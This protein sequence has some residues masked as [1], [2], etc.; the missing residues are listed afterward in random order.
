MNN[1]FNRQDMPLPF[2]VRSAGVSSRLLRARCTLTQPLFEL[3]DCVRDTAVPFEERVKQ[4]DVFRA[5]LGRIQEKLDKQSIELGRANERLKVYRT[6]RAARN[7]AKI[8]WGYMKHVADEHKSAALRQRIRTLQRTV[9]RL[10]DGRGMVRRPSRSLSTKG[11]SRKLSSFSGAKIQSVRSRES[12]VSGTS[13]DSGGTSRKAA[14]Q[15]KVLDINVDHVREHAAYERA[16]LVREQEAPVMDTSPPSVSSGVPSMGDVIA[17]NERLLAQT[18]ESRKTANAI[19]QILKMNRQMSDGGRWEEAAGGDE[20]DAVLDGEQATYMVPG[21]READRDTSLSGRSD[22]E[23]NLEAASKAFYAGLGAAVQMM[24]RVSTS[25]GGP[26]NDAETPA[27]ME[28]STA[29]GPDSVS[30]DSGDDSIGDEKSSMSEEDYVSSAPTLKI[31]AF[32]NLLRRTESNYTSVSGSTQSRR[33]IA[34]MREGLNRGTGL[35][36]LDSSLRQGDDD[37]GSDSDS[38]D[39]IG[40]ATEPYRGKREKTKKKKVKSEALVHASSSSELTR[41][42]SLTRRLPFADLSMSDGSRLAAYQA[43]IRDLSTEAAAAKDLDGEDGVVYDDDGVLDGNE[44]DAIQDLRSRREYHRRSRSSA[45]QST[46]SMTETRSRSQL[47]DRGRVSPDR[48]SYLSDSAVDSRSLGR[49]SVR[50]RRGMGGT[51][52]SPS[53]IADGRRSVEVRSLSPQSEGARRAMM[54]LTVSR[55]YSVYNEDYHKDAVSDM[56]RRVSH[57]RK[58]LRKE[59]EMQKE[60]SRAEV[61]LG[62]MGKSTASLLGGIQGLFGTA[63]KGDGHTPRSIHSGTVPIPG[64]LVSQVSEKDVSI[65]VDTAIS[66]AKVAAENVLRQQQKHDHGHMK[67]MEWVYSDRIERLENQIRALGGEVEL[68]ET[69]STSASYRRIHELQRVDANPAE[70]SEGTTHMSFTMGTNPVS[71]RRIDASGDLVPTAAQEDA[72]SMLPGASRLSG[73]SPSPAGERSRSASRLGVWKPPEEAQGVT[74]REVDLSVADAVGA[75]LGRFMAVPQAANTSVRSLFHS[76]EI[77]D[78]TSVPKTLSV[79]TGTQYHRD[80]LDSDVKLALVT[81]E[82]ARGNTVGAVIS[83]VMSERSDALSPMLTPSPEFNAPRSRQTGS[84]FSGSTALAKGRNGDA[85][86]L[87]EDASGSSGDDRKRKRM[88]TKH[89]TRP[90]SRGEDQQMFSRR[91]VMDMVLVHAA[92]LKEVRDAC[93]AR[94]LEVE[95]VVRR[96]RTVL[97]CEIVAHAIEAGLDLPS[98]SFFIETFRDWKLQLDVGLAGK[99]T[100]ASETGPRGGFKARMDDVQEKLVVEAA[101]RIIKM[102]DLSP[103]EVVA[104]IVNAEEN[105]EEDERTKVDRRVALIGD[106]DT[107]EIMRMRK[108]TVRGEDVEHLKKMNDE[109]FM[110]EAYSVTPLRQLREQTPSVSERAVLDDRLFTVTTE[111]AV[112]AP[113]FDVHS[114]IKGVSMKT[115]KNPTAR[116]AMPPP[117]VDASA[118]LRQLRRRVRSSWRS[119]AILTEEPGAMS[120]VER[121]TKGESVGTMLPPIESAEM[122]L[123]RF[124]SDPI[125]GDANAGRPQ[126]GLRQGTRG[127]GTDINKPMQSQRGRRWKS[128]TMGRGSFGVDGVC[129]PEEDDNGSEESSALIR[130]R[131]P[132]MLKTAPQMGVKR[133]SILGTLLDAAADAVAGR[134]RTRA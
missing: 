9:V 132:D 61:G 62:M 2:L 114:P 6:S 110:A 97:A 106:R 57:L 29:Q 67:L 101:L 93:V 83:R 75:V 78:P 52:G 71:G 26:A 44:K 37:S 49:H 108:R 85:D 80:D 65:V 91:E 94:V 66:V 23:H 59:E 89:D 30:D 63:E 16:R 11:S 70:G 7:W 82:Q 22:R 15:S 112:A 41:T 33:T 38:S 100:E 102:R 46:R 113:E 45:S 122:A 128:R 50:Q 103:E 77:R 130:G 18:A 54:G 60:Q 120:L 58:T 118:R 35:Q 68:E 90:D 105:M 56:S 115:K 96:L 17:E 131:V 104:R 19:H 76:F 81:E 125:K 14:Q 73:A 127:S 117:I 34:N 31:D 25:S 79:D 88:S 99:R 47:S 109:D 36:G 3:V 24:D 133:K 48:V 53:A 27:S 92:Q 8:G 124:R 123:K 134:L 51:L 116:V 12:M 28:I 69:L 55:K 1:I 86:S 107:W 21:E 84:R 64:D 10:R 72:T 95:D 129:A 43:R 13:V 98:I 4:I 126:R 32:A 5:E 74:E 40:A 111:G 119:T 121:S 87:D 20:L 39:S 42:T